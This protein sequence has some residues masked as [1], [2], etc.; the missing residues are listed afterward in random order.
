MN[1]VRRKHGSGGTPCSVPKASC[2]TGFQYQRRTRFKIEDYQK[3][4][5]YSIECT[6]YIFS[7]LKSSLH[8]CESSTLNSSAHIVFKES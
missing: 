1:Q 3:D 2:P 7:I 8:D 5:L 4:I 6:E